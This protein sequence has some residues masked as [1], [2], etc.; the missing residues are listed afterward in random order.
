MFS[1]LTKEERE[2]VTECQKCGHGPED[3]SQP[4]S[5]ETKVV[6]CMCCA[7]TSAQ[8]DAYGRRSLVVFRYVGGTQ[9]G[10]F[11]GVARM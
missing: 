2:L 1:D 9:R 7:T 3:H 4:I 11:S 10:H 8:G 6:S 5:H